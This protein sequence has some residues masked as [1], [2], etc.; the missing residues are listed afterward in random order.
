MGCGVEIGVRSELA[1]KPGKQ[2][3]HGCGDQASC[4]RP[5]RWPGTVDRPGFP[6]CAPCISSLDGGTSVSGPTWRSRRR[7][8]VR[9]PA[10]RRRRLD[11]WGSGL[12]KPL[13]RLGHDLRV[14]GGMTTV[15]GAASAMSTMWNRTRPGCGDGHYR[16]G[17]EHPAHT[18][19]RPGENL[20]AS[21]RAV[22]QTEANTGSS[23]KRSKIKDGADHAL[24]SSSVVTTADVCAIDQFLC[25]RPPP[26][27]GT[28]TI[29]GLVRRFASPY[30]CEEWWKRRNALSTAASPRRSPRSRK[31]MRRREVGQRLTWCETSSGRR[32]GFSAPR[33]R[34]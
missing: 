19:R 13:S 11:V 1:G 14:T 30:L 6:F 29:N 24:P 10:A 20:L 7:R 12:T 9:S 22:Y 32:G 34:K 31:H 26:R 23:I 8:Q 21:G 16:S 15:T 18:V 5:R 17:R 28:G 27:I 25:A 33:N 4:S 2:T 3:F